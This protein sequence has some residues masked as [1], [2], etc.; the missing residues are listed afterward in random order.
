MP[1]GPVAIITSNF[2]PEP[3]GISQTVT[4]F[5]RF[6]A[7]RNIDVR[8][9]TAMPYYPQWRIW[10][11]YR[12]LLRL[13]E[14]HQGCSILR[15]WHYARPKPSTRARLLHEATLSLFAVP[16]MFRT[17][18]GA[19]VAYVVSPALSYAVI[20]LVIAALLRIERVLIVKDVM[21]D[22]A[23]ELGMLRNPLVVAVT[24]W[25]A[26]RAYALA[27]EIHT[28]GEG[29]R[30]RI[31]RETGPLKP[32]RIVPD[33]VDME[34][35]RPV[36]REDNEFRRRFIPDQMFAVL[37]TGN[38]G[39]KQDL[40]LLLRAAAR[41]RD[42]PR[43]HF[44]VVG[45]G[46]AKDEF[47]R[48]REEL[49]LSNVSHHPLQERWM[50]PHMLSGADVVL[51]SQLAEVVDI[52]MPSKLITSLAAG[53]MIVATC[54]PDSE[55]ARLVKLSGGGVA[56][57]AGDDAALVD[58][59]NGIRRGEVDVAGCRERGRTFAEKAFKRDS[60]YGQL[61]DELLR[62]WDAEARSTEV[63]RERSRA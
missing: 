15:S 28:L 45:D 38:M 55:T 43:V 9:A 47:L 21:P 14:R 35:L 26:R 22:A 52:V 61:V 20:G 19:R 42:D 41:L 31:S 33:T 12:G 4:E 7:D 37:H 54:S 39:R 10:P 18:R 11:N 13:S 30:R 23:I 1:S 40:G 3:T 58:A 63:A 16:N 57:A 34:E 8:V 5:A 56:V 29:M 25:L 44:F 24:R 17:L 46:A 59:I 60:V 27:G 36:P 53:A 2:W 48:S 50:L 62:K 51:V 6:L 49:G 32:I